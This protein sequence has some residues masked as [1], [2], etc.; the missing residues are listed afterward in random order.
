MMDQ[1]PST[2]SGSQQDIVRHR[3]PSPAVVEAGAGTGKTFTIVERVASLHETGA[4]PVDRIL[5]LTFARKAAAELKMRFAGRMQ[6]PPDCF[7][8]HAFAWNVL[9]THAYDVG[10]S[11]DA[12][13]I[14]DVEARVHFHKAFEEYLREPQSAACGFPLRPHNVEE[15]RTALFGIGQTLKQ[16]GISLTQFRERAV[17]AA[18]EFSRVPYRELRKKT[19]QGKVEAS[20]SDAEF[21]EE[22][23]LERQRIDAAVLI[24]ETF[25]R[26]MEALNSLSYADILILAERAIREDPVLADQLR[27]RYPY[28]IVDEYQDTDLAQHRLLKALYG[29]DLLNVMVVGDVL[30][31]IY[32]FR[33]AHPQNVEA[34]KSL[35]GAH[36]YP[37]IENRR[38][39]QEILDLGYAV[40]RGTHGDARHLHAERGRAGEQNVHISS[41]W[42]PES[43][44]YLP[45]DEARVLEASVVGR[46]ICGLLTSGTMVE[47]SDGAPRP[48]S[49]RDIAIL[50]RNK[51]KVQAVTNALLEMG[52]PFRLVGGVGFYDAGEVRDALAWLRLA[53]DPMDAHAITRA[54][55]S[56]VM[57]ATDAELAAV[58]HGLKADETAFST[59]VL[60]EAAAEDA[61]NFTGEGDGN[62]IARFRKLAD[63]IALC[64]ALPLMS[65]LQT[66]LDKTGLRS[67]W[68]E[69]ADARA[70]QALANLL[71]LESL[72]RGFAN[73]LPGALPADFIIFIDEL[74]RIEFDEREADVVSLDAVTISTIHAAKGLEW[75]VVFVLG[76]WPQPGKRARLFV[77]EASGAL[78]YAENPDGSISFHH[79]A[80]KDRADAQGVLHK[81]D[82]EEKEMAKAEECRLFYVAIT[83][84]RDLLYLSGFRSKR[85]PRNPDGKPHDYLIAAYDW[86]R[87]KG[88]N[89]DEGVPAHPPLHLGVGP[90]SNGSA[91]GPRQAVREQIAAV[92]SATAVP[93][94]SYSSIACYEQCPRRVTYKTMFRLPEIV[95]T[96]GWTPSRAP[97]DAASNAADD[98][99]PEDSILSV[100]EQGQLVHKALELWALD[101][102]S[103]TSRTPTD[104]VA[105][106]V[107]AL[108]LTPPAAKLSAMAASVGR[109]SSSLSGWMPLHVEAPFTLDLGEE[110]SRLLVSG[111]ID[112]VAKD[113][114][115]R[116]C[117]LD[118][119]TGDAHEASHY[120]L[121][122]ALYQAAVRAVYAIPDARCFIGRIGERAFSLEP[123]TPIA[124]EELSARILAVRNGLRAQNVTPIPGDWCFSCPYRG[125]PCQ[126]YKR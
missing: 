124:N 57:G 126:D 33:G 53:A 102:M 75:P 83:R 18:E 30:Q 78:L 71:K 14:D 125:A 105:G 84:A 89:S 64:S 23:V 65:A 21:A 45:V 9:S 121:Q 62:V 90:R 101:R 110:G 116:S 96:K 12:V 44:E 17:R 24:L 87:A 85:S 15:I 98:G 48:I 52:I 82:A 50:S 97:F 118:Y 54:L 74:E 94:L 37:L 69:N 67:Y 58:S 22:L 68:E 106:A 63:E 29:D 103:G 8:F 16:D 6:T 76:I 93:A 42:F 49:P 39:R 20:V 32:G 61:S 31:S 77:D 46:R 99:P 117:L 2:L 114:T 59:R 108:N 41:M 123:V 13:V 104:Y 25:N 80:V 3:G 111:Y 70:P 28:C 81:L 11:P 86:L 115:G 4:C 100:G 36:V 91:S 56:P 72:A 122:V 47:G 19:L 113:E 7:T 27:Q 119:K 1:R 51:T 79:T 95:A 88:W 38:S 60:V 10:L 73:D 5:V 40:I 120:A 43:V 66:I 92:P 109:V 107:Q 34:I 112:L 35:A 26:R 55:Q